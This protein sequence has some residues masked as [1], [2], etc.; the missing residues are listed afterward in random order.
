MVFRPVDG[1]RAYSTTPT[2][3][4]NINDA[5]TSNET[6]CDK[7]RYG[8]AYSPSH[9]CRRYAQTLRRS[10]DIGTQTLQLHNLVK[11]YRQWAHLCLSGRWRRQHSNSRTEHMTPCA[12]RV[13]IICRHVQR[14]LPIRPCRCPVYPQRPLSRAQDILAILRDFVQPYTRLVFRDNTGEMTGIRQRQQRK[15]VWW[16]FLC[17]SLVARSYIRA[18]SHHTYRFVAIIGHAI[19]G[20]HRA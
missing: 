12:V 3:G 15:R 16:V 18:I 20:H 9:I 19:C 8:T 2:I 6:G 4:G 13:D 17:V 14:G 7:P 11:A 10:S 1:D 5:D